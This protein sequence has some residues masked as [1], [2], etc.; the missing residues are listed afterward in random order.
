MG[1]VEVVGGRGNVEEGP[2]EVTEDDGEGGR[3]EGGLCRREV[4]GR[5]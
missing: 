4:A 1:V 3:W 2:D 5:V